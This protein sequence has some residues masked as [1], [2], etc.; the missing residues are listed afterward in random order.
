MSADL[1]LRAA[2]AELEYARNEVGSQQGL[3][4]KGFSA[5]KEFRDAQLRVKRAEEEVNEAQ[6][7][8]NQLQAAVAIEDRFSE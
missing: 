2:Q 7:I 4:E 3:S 5:G 1:E 8:L 6:A